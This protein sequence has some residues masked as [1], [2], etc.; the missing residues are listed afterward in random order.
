MA[1][2]R[3]EEGE[4]IEGTSDTGPCPEAALV[5]CV[6]FVADRLRLR[7]D[8]RACHEIAAGV[9]RA[10]ALAARMARVQAAALRTASVEVRYQ[11][12]GGVVVD[13]EPTERAIV[14]SLGIVEKNKD[15]VMGDALVS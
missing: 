4:M 2:V 3:I 11:V 13:R 6:G 8:R 14:K 9:G 7:V 15:V 1:T 10:T 5:H 12:I